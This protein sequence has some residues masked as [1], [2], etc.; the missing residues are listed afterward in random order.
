MDYVGGSSVEGVALSLD[1]WE[2]YEVLQR[3]A[4]DS[5]RAFTAM[6]YGDELLN[7]MVEHCFRPAVAQSGFSLVLLNDPDQQRA[8]LIDDRL[9]VE[10]RASRF[11]IVDLTHGNQGAYWEAGFAEGLG[12]PVIYTC[13]QSIFDDPKRRPHF[14]T[15]HHLTVPWIYADM[16]KAR[17][18]LKA[19]IRAT[20]PTEAQ[21]TDTD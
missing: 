18:L 3:G 10:I 15:N 2:R 6:Q 20:L 16:D 13:E 21:L 8:G 14:D 1:G 5:R 4:S 17:E 12:K 9:R 11:L 19:V 7:K